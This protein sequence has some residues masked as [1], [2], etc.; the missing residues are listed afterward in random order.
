MNKALYDGWEL[1]YFDKA[2]NFR[3]YQFELVKKFIGG[4][5]AEVGPGNGAFLKYYLQLA[6]EIDLFE[7]SENFLIS[8][9]E[10]KDPKVN[11]IN[12]FFEKNKN[13]YDTILYLDVLEHIK[14]DKMEIQTA[15]ESLNKGG[16]LVIN[17]PA[18][19]HLYSQ[20]D[21]DV[22]HF[23]RYSKNTLKSL[24]AN[25]GFTST[26]LIYFD[27]IGYML[28]IASKLVTKDYLKNFDKKIKI[29]DSLIPLSKLIDLLVLNKFGKSLI[30]ICI[31]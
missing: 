28:S 5:V 21:K 17:V 14:D 6:T 18:F 4:K 12:K 16:A 25:I 2:F 13:Y 3:N 29:W 20:F 27:S 26:K 15:F 10:F 9:N 30:M 19:Q 24:T 7:P 1:K 11:I 31:K 23:R 8:L 22:D